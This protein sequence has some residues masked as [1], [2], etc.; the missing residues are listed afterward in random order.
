MIVVSMF[1]PNA[2]DIVFDVKYYI[3]T[4]I[5]KIKNLLEPLGL[6]D[7]QIQKGISSSNPGT[8]PKYFAVTY[9]NFNSVEEA[10]DAFTIAARQIIKDVSN[11]TNCSPEFQI[12]E[13]IF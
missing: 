1:F 4:H 10:H 9:L 2:N 7:I 8:P 12:S 6:I 3:E 11:F 13:F 5:E